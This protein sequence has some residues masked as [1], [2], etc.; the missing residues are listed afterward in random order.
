MV[1]LLYSMIWVFSTS[2]SALQLELCRDSSVDTIILYWY[3]IMYY[4]GMMW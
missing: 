3:S 1:P 4:V 2:S